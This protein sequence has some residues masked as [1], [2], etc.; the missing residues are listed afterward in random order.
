MSKGLMVQGTATYVLH[1]APTD[2]VQSRDRADKVMACPSFPPCEPLCQ[3][4]PLQH[5]S[6]SKHHEYSAAH[7][8]LSEHAPSRSFPKA[9]SPTTPSTPD[10]GRF[11]F[12]IQPTVTST[13][14]ISRLGQVCTAHY[15][16]ICSF[17]GS[18]RRPQNHPC[19]TTSFQ[20]P[21]PGL[22]IISHICLSSRDVHQVLPVTNRVERVRN[23]HFDYP[24]D[25]PTN[26][27]QSQLPPAESAVVLH[28]TA[29]PEEKY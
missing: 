10:R 19:Q 28:M 13:S 21:F 24:T 22:G 17:V 1:L 23:H 18:T 6:P 14:S 20:E 15:R 16:H 29:Q 4:C 27:I 3:Y 12:T 7:S 8:V 25:E 26:Q 9:P 11:G 5:F 2:R